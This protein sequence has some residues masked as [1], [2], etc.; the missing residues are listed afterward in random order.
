MPNPHKH[1]NGPS[2]VVVV[3]VYKPGLTASELV[4]LRQCLSVLGRYPVVVIKP[5]RLGL[6]ELAARFP[7]LQFMSFGDDYFA[8]IDGYNRLMISPDFYR[9]FERYEYML[10]HQLDA[11]VFSDQLDDWCRSGYDYLG[12]PS[13]EAAA[14]DA[15][16][17]ADSGEFARALSSGR[18]VLNGG[19]SLRRIPS[20]RR[21]LK[22]HNFLLP[23]WP[24]NEDMLFSLDS[25][26]L[27]PLRFL[28]RLPGWEEALRFA[29]EKSPSASY[30]IT[31]EKLPFG[32]HAWAR[33][34]PD[35]WKTFI[36]GE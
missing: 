5:E 10:V 24:G 18:V 16:Q 17:A 1:I 15:L 35:F 25:R 14:F 2:A 23:P 30:R 11:Y 8:G 31:G 21:F 7:A 22:I 26:R 3:P 33:Y 6:D 4:S 36:P 12:A 20:I 9:R 28:L 34:D 32:C 19:L 29:F 27:R 13:V